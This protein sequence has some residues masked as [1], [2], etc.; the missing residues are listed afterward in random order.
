MSLNKHKLA[1]LLATGDGP[2]FSRPSHNAAAPVTPCTRL[3]LASRF[4]FEFTA[5]RGGPGALIGRRQ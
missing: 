1:A 5:E 2:E 3:L 4:P